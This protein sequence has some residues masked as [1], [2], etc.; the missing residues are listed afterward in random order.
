MIQRTSSLATL[1]QR[2]CFSQAQQHT[3]SNVPTQQACLGYNTL[4][5]AH[6]EQHLCG[7]IA[8][9]HSCSRATSQG[10]G[11][12][13]PVLLELITRAGLAGLT[14]LRGGCLLLLAT[15]RR[16]CRAG[17]SVAG[18]LV[19]WHTVPAL[20]AAQTP[21][22]AQVTAPLPL[23]ACSPAT[24]GRLLGWRAG[25]HCVSAQLCW[26]L[27]VSC[28]LRRPESSGVVGSTCPDLA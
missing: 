8:R 13:H 7:R 15:G 23:H 10:K 19:G 2:M 28:T 24:L 16:R 14:R 12:S 3:P 21:Q 5:C 11:A 17:A 22:P 6:A 18:V 25:V 26:P 9:Q 4:A 27:Q 20:L 1:Q